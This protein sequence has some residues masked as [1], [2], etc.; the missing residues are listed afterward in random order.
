MGTFFQYDIELDPAKL[1]KI[2]TQFGGIRVTNY[3]RNEIHFAILRKPRRKAIKANEGNH[4]ISDFFGWP[5][6]PDSIEF[7]YDISAGCFRSMG[8]AE[9]EFLAIMEVIIKKTNP[10]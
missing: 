1:E 3:V 8:M 4:H 5:V 10:E 6:S 7:F 9:R 2:A